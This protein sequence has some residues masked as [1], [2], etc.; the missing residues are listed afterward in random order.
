MVI[1]RLTA[2]S[3]TADMIVKRDEKMW[4]AAHEFVCQRFKNYLPV[5][6]VILKPQYN[7]LAEEIAPG[8][9]GYTNTS[10]DNV[11][12]LL[13]KRYLN[14][15]EIDEV[16]KL[17]SKSRKRERVVSR[18]ALRDAVRSFVRG[19]REEMIYPLEI[20]Y[21]HDEN[22]K[23][24]VY[25]ERETRGLL[26]GIHVSL[27]HKDATAVA[28]AAD[29]PVGIDIEMIEEKSESFADIAFTKR[30]QKLL[31]LFP[32]PEGSIR[33]WVAKEACAKKAGTGIKSSPKRFE[34][35]AVDGDVLSIGKEKVQTMP[36]GKDYI[37]GWTI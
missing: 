22:G 3:I 6:N 17:E 20:F 11:L 4:C 13:G 35:N 23:P 31:S 21:R 25:G 12:G 27:A 15:K 32:E 26:E 16:D 28:V 18:I 7:L 34:V 2:T 37:V 30:E 36:W 33:F 24:Q 8:I 1:T 5:W 29:R 9:F 10:E 19:D 14:H